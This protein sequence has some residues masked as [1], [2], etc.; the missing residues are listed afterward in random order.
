[1]HN[2]RLCSIIEG[3]Q[4]TICVRGLDVRVIVLLQALERYCGASDDA[5]TW[6][7]MAER[8]AETL[9][10]LAVARY[11]ATGKTLV[12]IGSNR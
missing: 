8:H 10:R 2:M 3:I 5:A 9:E 1:M 7:A 4:A 6:L 11:E 12:I